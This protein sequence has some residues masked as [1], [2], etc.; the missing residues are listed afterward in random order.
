MLR[1]YLT[2]YIILSSIFLLHFAVVGQAVYGDGIYYWSYTR[3]LSLDHDLNFANELS[4]R[5]NPKHNNT[6]E[7]EEVAKDLPKTSS[8]RVFNK[9]PPVA[10]ILWIPFFIIADILITIIQSFSIQVSKNGYSDLYQI[11]VGLGNIS[12]IVSGIYFLQKFLT[13]YSKNGTKF[14]SLICL[15]LLFAT[16]LLFYG[17]IDVINSHPVAFFLSTLFFYCWFKTNKNRSS[18]KWFLLGILGGLLGATRTLDSLILILPII[19][20]LFQKSKQKKLK[21]VKYLKQSFIFIIGSVIGFSPQLI[22]WYSLNSTIGKDP[23]LG[24]GTELNFLTP[25]ILGL[26]FNFKTGFL[27]YSPLLLI[28]LA[29]MFFVY[30]KNRTLGLSLSIIL[31]F[32]YYLIASW[33]GWHQGES[34]GMRMFISLFPIFALGLLEVVLAVRRYFSLY[35]IYFLSLIFILHTLFMIFF[36]L[37][38]LQSPAIDMGKSTQE[39]I[40]HRVYQLLRI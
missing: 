8:G 39:A 32:Y 7:D 14:I 26:I 36:F 5:Y 37:L 31:L 23:Y 13:I 27:F 24:S 29:G 38:I 30:K 25:H 9:Y 2:I 6:S 34:Y 28:A 16:D 20:E 1:K 40:I 11:L 10:P 3:S 35:Y 4:H 21:I 12:F 33:N 19:Y 17:S 22:A 15:L 18:S